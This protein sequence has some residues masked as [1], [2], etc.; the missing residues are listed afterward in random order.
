MAHV[1]WTPAAERDLEDIAYYIGVTDHRP[2]TAMRLIDQLVAKCQL[3]ATQPAMGARY[4]ELGENL[5]LFRH[6]RYVVI[7]KPHEAGIEV[8][9]VVDGSRDYPA[10][11]AQPK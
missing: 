11:L 9:R 2:S 10:L 8:L 3:Y 1:T 5:R 6:K 4:P 7:Y